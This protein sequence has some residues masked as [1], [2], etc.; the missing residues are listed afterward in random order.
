MPATSLEPTE[1]SGAKDRR[2]SPKDGKT[3][4]VPG[5]GQTP[6]EPALHRLGVDAESLG[7]VDLPEA[8][9]GQSPPQ[10][11]DRRCHLYGH[12]LPP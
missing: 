4:A 1:L 8:R 11:T 7:D 2:A 10:G 6:G 5:L 12:G 3:P 9:L